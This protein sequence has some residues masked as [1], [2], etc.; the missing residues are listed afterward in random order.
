M[1][2]VVGAA[3][4]GL[5][6]W[7]SAF[8]VL[9]QIVAEEDMRLIG[10]ADS[11]APHLEEARQKYSPD[12]AVQD[13]RQILD[14]ERID[15]LF[16]FVPTAKNV[17]VCLQA[18]GR[19][20]H[21]FCVKPPAMT[22]EDAIRLA[23]A[24]EDAGVFFSSFEVYHRLSQRSQFLKKII[25]D[26][27][28]GEPI[29]FYHVAHGGLPQPWMEQTGPSWWL[30]PAL[31]P[32]GA[33]IDHAIYAVDQVR[34]N[35]EREVASVSGVISNRRHKDFAMEDHG[36]A[37]VRLGNGFT[38]I[39]EDSWTADVGTRFDRWIGT[40]GSLYPDGSG[41]VVAKRGELERLE[42]EA[43]SKSTVAQLADAV[44]GR[45]KLP[46]TNACCVHNLAACLAVYESA[47]TGKTVDVLSG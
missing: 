36:I 9:D 46:F 30:D 18:L 26:G 11:N 44:R 8:M 19:G 5:D 27:V 29:S 47:R 6:H 20:K 13:Y 17:E 21:V 31:V 3:V 40:D 24:A 43:E 12:S 16:S 28:I 37:I 25:Q 7:Y 2:E 33:W 14:D 10:I 22:V 15:L 23:T 42:P 45:Q 4:I 39:M 32:G 1:A 35:L 41:F 34:W 38:A